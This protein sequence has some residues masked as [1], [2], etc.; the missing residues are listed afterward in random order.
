MIGRL[1]LIARLG[2]GIG[3]V[4]MLQPWWADGFRYGFFVTGVFAVVH[5]VTSHL[6]EPDVGEG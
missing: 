3:V 4:M 1:D 6:V 5:I 2:L